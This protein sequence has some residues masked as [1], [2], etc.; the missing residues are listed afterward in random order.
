[1][2]PKND[3]TLVTNRKHKSSHTKNAV[4]Q[5]KTAAT[6]RSQ[7]P[8][9]RIRRFEVVGASKNGIPYENCTGILAHFN[10]EQWSFTAKTTRRHYNN[11]P[12]P[13]GY[14][15][16]YT[17]Y[18]KYGPFNLHGLPKDIVSKILAHFIEMY[19]ISFDDISR[20]RN[21]CVEWKLWFF[22][23]INVMVRLYPLIP[24]TKDSFWHTY[25]MMKNTCVPPKPAVVKKLVFSF[26]H[27]VGDGYIG[28]K[29]V[30][31]GSIIDGYVRLFMDTYHPH[32]LE[33]CLRLGHKMFH[34]M[35]K[36]IPLQILQK[37]ERNSK[38]SAPLVYLYLRNG[39]RCNLTSF[40]YLPPRFVRWFV[41]SEWCPKY[42][43][44]VDELIQGEY[45]LDML[46]LYCRIPMNCDWDQQKCR[47]GERYTSDEQS[48][49]ACYVRCFEE[50]RSNCRVVLGY[51]IVSEYNLSG[52]V[53][54]YRKLPTRYVYKWFMYNLNCADVCDG[55]NHT[56]DIGKLEENRKALKMMEQI[57]IDNKDVHPVETLV[58]YEWYLQFTDT[59]FTV[60]DHK[61][62]ASRWAEEYK[63]TLSVWKQKIEKK[64]KKLSRIRIERYRDV[65]MLDDIG[66]VGDG[67]DDSSPETLRR[68]KNQQIMHF[69]ARDVDECD[70]D[71]EVSTDDSEDNSDDGYD[72]LEPYIDN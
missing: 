53:Y 7:P 4:V 41:T 2:P 13:E 39:M 16:N 11:E 24:S 37:L 60:Y 6:N 67:E 46:E 19:D 18:D 31:Y 56:F 65:W 25:Y 26:V 5:P 23:D 52:L 40:R 58:V 70:L 27:R 33:K 71:M 3:W 22:N 42:P 43:C 44:C 61:K 47:R 49:L 68:R 63:Q 32:F 38:N 59:N 64:R 48:K 36:L 57:V 12:F 30:A 8:Q 21:V 35:F 10:W 28:K 69:Q 15:F 51:G 17:K 20:L 50:F 34:C 72:I 9:Q 55:E 45:P 1:M 66:V 54:F 14:D 29:N 62:E